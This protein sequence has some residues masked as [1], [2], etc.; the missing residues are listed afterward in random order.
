MTS[1]PD[2]STDAPDAAAAEHS[3]RLAALIRQEAAAKGG[4]IPFDRFMELALYAPGL[5]YYV[6]GAR[7]LGRQGDFVTA[8]ELSPLFGRCV[9]SQCRE[10]LEALDG[11]DILELGAGS[12]ILAAEVLSAL[13]ATG[14]LPGRYLILELSP[15]L[16]ERQ[17]ILLAK[18]VPD[19]LA[20]VQWLDRLPAG[21]RGCVLANEVLDA[22]PVHRFRIGANGEPL[23]LFVRP[24][25]DGWAE[26]AAEPVSPGLAETVRAL[27]N[28]GL[29][30][31]PGYESEINLRLGPWI[32]ALAESMEQGLALLIDYGY[33]RSEYYL[34]DRR[35]GTLMCH[36]RHCAHTDPFLHP[37]LQDITAHVDFTAV[38]EAGS[39]AGLRLAGYTTQAHFLIGCGLDRLLAEATREADTM[40]LIL[41]AKQ[42]VMPSDMGERFQVVGLEKG[43]EAPLAGFSFRDLR[44]RLGKP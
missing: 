23:E 43:V 24:T 22:M 19:L 31:D 12:G 6:A 20:R 35:G 9:A 26:T 21:F 14:C 11:G 29:A 38:A 5:G 32:R 30:L 2:T 15:D 42:L 36:Y 44:G 13:S 3:R 39:L 16:R 41:G 7:K 33:P 40:D 34:A 25:P 17:Q 1:I 28:E 10:V 18:R 27:R 4:H 8:P 37:G